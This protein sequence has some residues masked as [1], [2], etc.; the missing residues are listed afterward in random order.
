MTTHRTTCAHCGRELTKKQRWHQQDHCS[1]VCWRAASLKGR[2][3]SVGLPAT[4][5]WRAKHSGRLID[6]G[7]ALVVTTKRAC[8]ECGQ[9]RNIRAKH[10]L[11][12]VCQALGYRWCMN[13]Q[14]TYQG[15]A[16]RC[17]RQRNRL[18]PPHG[19]VWI[20]VAAKRMGY[21]VTPVWRAIQRGWMAGKVLKVG[22][23]WC[24]V[25]WPRYPVWEW[26]V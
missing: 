22:P 20:S 8:A 7:D 26:A 23:R 12:D 14:H 10:R 21:S 24:I 17:P 13:G 2:A 16:C 9:R 5:V 15:T 18:A 3:E 11:C 19:Y 25:D 1:R 4:K 6:H